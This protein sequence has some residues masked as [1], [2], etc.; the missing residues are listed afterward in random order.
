MHFG[1][2]IPASAE[3][4]NAT[5]DDDMFLSTQNGEEVDVTGIE[6]DADM[7]VN[8]QD[9]DNIAANEDAD[10]STDEVDGTGGNKG[11]DKA[12]SFSALSSIYLSVIPKIP[13]PRR[14]SAPRG[15]AEPVNIRLQRDQSEDNNSGPELNP[16]ERNRRKKKIQQIFGDDQL[17]EEYPVVNRKPTKRKLYPQSSLRGYNPIRAARLVGLYSLDGELTSHIALDCGQGV[18]EPAY[19]NHCRRR[20]P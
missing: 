20:N 14:F 18:D 17:E 5:E 16:R 15:G 1:G 10:M 7:I 6:Q 19:E 13:P 4:F 2:D 8:S 3:E 12:S 9:E 11:K